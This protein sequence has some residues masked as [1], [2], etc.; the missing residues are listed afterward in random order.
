MLEARGLTKRYSGKA[1]VDAVS[2]TAGR[3]AH[4]KLV[5]YKNRSW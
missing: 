4:N 3:S 2:F 1:V 5:V